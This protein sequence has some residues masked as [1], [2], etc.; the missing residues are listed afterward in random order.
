MACSSSSV[1]VVGSL[2]KE[3]S[4]ST[5]GF[6]GIPIGLRF[7]PSDRDLVIHYLYKN[8]EGFPLPSDSTVPFCDLYGHQE[9]WE[10][11][12]AF[13]GI[14]NENLFFFTNLKKM[15]PII[16]RTN[17]QVGSSGGTWQ[18]E[19][20]NKRSG[21]LE[22]SVACQDIQLQESQIQ[23]SECTPTATIVCRLRKKK[24]KRKRQLDY[25]EEDMDKN[26]KRSM[27]D[28]L[29][30]STTFVSVS[31]NPPHSLLPDHE[32]DA[33]LEQ[34]AATNNNSDEHLSLDG[35][36]A[37]EDQLQYYNMLLTDDIL[38]TEPSDSND[39]L[40]Q[41]QIVGNGEEMALDDDYFHSIIQELLCEEA[42]TLLQ[43]KDETLKC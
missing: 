38:S 32:N 29:A 1:V 20:R 24:P 41:R 22:N 11:W 2:D 16:S 43:L 39:A 8:V 21:W 9:P 42:P 40:R 37:P 7:Q 5:V 12:D 17:R 4:K 31:V 36:D 15:S 19:G 28:R 25:E 33:I 10:I 14:D 23:G 18:D 13:G 34:D 35:A 27:G 26:C 3:L 30:M 6:S